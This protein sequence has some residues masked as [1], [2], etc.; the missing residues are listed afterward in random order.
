VRQSQRINARLLINEKRDALVLPRGP[1]VETHG[2]RFVYVVE[3]GIAWR[4][5]V[6]LGATSVGA[7]EILAGLKAGDRVVVAGAEAFDNAA[8]VKINE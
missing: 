5:P 4:R 8:Q 7:I 2:G 6:T 1:F 3:N